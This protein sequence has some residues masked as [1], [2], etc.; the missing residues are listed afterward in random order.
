M[1][2]KN[3]DIINILEE[4]ALNNKSGTLEI[5]TPRK[6][7]NK[8]FYLY[9]ASGEIVFIEIEPSENSK[10]LGQI[11]LNY[12]H[13]T[14]KE[15]KEA[16]KEQENNPES[17]LGDIFLER[18][19]IDQITLFQLFKYKIQYIIFLLNT[20]TNKKINF[21]EGKLPER[22]PQ[23]PYSITLKQ[24]INIQEKIKQ[25]LQT[26]EDFNIDYTDKIKIKNN[27]SGPLNPEEKKI[28]NL[29][30]YNNYNIIEVINKTSIV[31]PINFLSILSSF[32]DRDVIEFQKSETGKDSDQ[33]EEND[34]AEEIKAEDQSKNIKNI[35]F[36]RILT[37]LEEVIPVIIFLIFVY[38]FLTNL[39]YDN[40]YLNI[41]TNKYSSTSIKTGQTENIL[42]II[43]YYKEN[44]LMNYPENDSW[45]NKIIIKD[46][47]IISGGKDTQ[48]DTPDDIKITFYKNSP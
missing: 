24:I 18:N 7:N 16:L 47:Q 30:R 8:N 21:Q 25:N 40:S 3:N 6:E 13:I 32:L 5:I 36:Q 10:L 27:L 33:V 42:E 38:I 35:F 12:K 28:F 45:G 48:I 39:I 44:N 15:L 14:E 1:N 31:S 11:L 19:T 46:N 26:F 17:F 34:T 20:I 43:K 37:T 9:F 22:T 41:F 23:I 2:E 4:I 29:I